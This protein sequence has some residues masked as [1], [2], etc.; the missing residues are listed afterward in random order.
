MGFLLRLTS[1]SF[2]LLALSEHFP[3]LVLVS[4]TGSWEVDQRRLDGS[5]VQ[6]T[7]LTHFRH[8]FGYAHPRHPCSPLKG[9]HILYEPYQF[10]ISGYERYK[11]AVIKESLRLFYGMPGELPRVVQPSGAL[12]CGQAIPPAVSFS[13]SSGNVDLT[14]ATD[15]RIM[16]SLC[17]SPRRINLQGLFCFLSRSLV[18]Q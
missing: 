17:Q 6:R 10:G 3:P 7:L 4:L 16:L 14:H 15:D 2:N 12:L 18:G 8:C 13:H 1:I 9:C 11:E 5:S